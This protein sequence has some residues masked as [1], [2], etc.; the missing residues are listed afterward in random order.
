MSGYQ[1]DIL[2]TGL[3]AVFCGIN[4]AA[5]AERAG[6]NF[7]TPSNRFWTVLHLSGF[8]AER[9][10]PQDE[11]RLLDFNC[12]VT[13]VVRRPTWRADEVSPEEFRR[14]RP[15]FEERM[16]RFAPRSLAFLGK[17]AFT[18]MMDVGDVSWGH[19]PEAFAGIATWI[20]PNPS[21]FNRG[22]TLDALVRA[23][24]ELRIAL[25]S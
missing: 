3:R 16:R 23:Y 20:L 4:P 21:G 18:A 11:R 1:P 7:S 6:H 13:A 25:E 14:A 19:Q 15:E 17:R 2:K 22:F 12:G 9:L 5:S 24:S 8:T 10:R